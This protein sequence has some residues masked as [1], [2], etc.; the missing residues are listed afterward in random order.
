MKNKINII[1]VNNINKSILNFLQN[2]LGNIFKT[3]I[4]IFDKIDVP[5]NSFDKSRNQYSADKILNYLCEKLTIKNIQ[6][7]NLAILNIDI[8]VPSLNFVFGLAIS[9][10]K[11][12]LISTARLNPLFYPYFKSNFI[13]KIKS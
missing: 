7:I 10:P 11:I 4:Y 12:C 13:K 6:D 1:P 3:D 9:F 8:F 5:K 2:N